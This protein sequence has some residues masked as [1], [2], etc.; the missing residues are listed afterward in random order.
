MLDQVEQSF[1]KYAKVA[2]PLDKDAE[3][4]RASI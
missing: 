3:I 1:R 2:F 4:N